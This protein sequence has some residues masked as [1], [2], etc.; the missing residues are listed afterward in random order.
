MSDVA[1]ETTSDLLVRMKDCDLCHQS[2]RVV[3][4]PSSKRE[5]AFD[6]PSGEEH[7]CWDLPQGLSPHDL[8]ILSDE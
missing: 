8:M 4:D 5:L 1:S 6:H 7:A 2:I 3:S